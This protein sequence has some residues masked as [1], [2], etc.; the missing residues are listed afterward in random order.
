MKTRYKNTPCN[1]FVDEAGDPIVFGK[2]KST[3]IGTNGAS[4]FFL[5]GLLEIENPSLLTHELEKLRGDFLSN[6]KLNKLPGMRPEDGLTAE[7]FH[8]SDDHPIIR[9]LVYSFLNAYKGIK[10]TCVIKDKKSVFEY[11]RQR[12]ARD[13]SYKYSQSELY[14][15]CV[16]KLFKERLHRH[17][18]YN[19]TFAKWNKTKRHNELMRAL[20]SG[21]ELFYHNYPHLRV[22]NVIKI[23]SCLLVGVG[24]LQAVDYYLWAIQRIYEKL[25]ESYFNIVTSGYSLI[26]DLDDTR[27]NPYGV[28]Y[29]KG[30]PLT[31]DE[32]RGRL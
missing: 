15:F 1:Y 8:A 19:I 5:I 11:I 10:F 30:K 14:D 2:N 22:D 12:Q 13:E 31:L 7:K 9:R 17:S 3:R 21:R 18:L 20:I 27:K 6:D 16:R 26:L 32:V 24:G 29:D 4:R 25:D 23:E 28:Y